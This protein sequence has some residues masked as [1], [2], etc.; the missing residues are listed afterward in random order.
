MKRQD[1]DDLKTPHEDLDSLMQ[2]FEQAWQRLR[3]EK[4]QNNGKKNNI[5]ATSNS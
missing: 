1:P 4:E 2:A 5:N 3:Y